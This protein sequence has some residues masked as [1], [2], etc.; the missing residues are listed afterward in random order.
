M[1]DDGNSRV[2]G[3][4]DSRDGPSVVHLGQFV[5]NG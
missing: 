3:N 2:A 4:T 5:P 1:S